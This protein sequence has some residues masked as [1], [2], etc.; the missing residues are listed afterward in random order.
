MEEKTGERKKEELLAA[1]EEARRLWLE[2]L[3]AAGP[4]RME[5][6]GA[7]GAWSLKDL[8]AHLAAYVQFSADRLEERLRGET[9]LRS[10][11]DEDLAAFALRFGVPDFGSW[12]LNDDMANGWVHGRWH[13]RTLD[14]ALK[15]EEGQYARLVAAVR[16][17]P[18][19][20]LAK[21]A[22]TDSRDDVAQAI[23]TNSVEHYQEHVA[24]ARAWLDSVDD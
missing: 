11:D 20:L 14:E 9:Y 16:E 8:A 2:L 4:G 18:A 24:E 13:S 3:A 12:L 23:L 6:G 1:M 15:Y 7:M 22:I 21:P 17:A 19:A 5:R 10:T